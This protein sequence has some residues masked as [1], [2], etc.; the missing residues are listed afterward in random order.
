MTERMTTQLGGLDVTQ[1]K[2]ITEWEEVKHPVLQLEG[3]AE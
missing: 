3:V 1:S 2:N